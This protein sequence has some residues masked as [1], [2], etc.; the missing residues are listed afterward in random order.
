MQHDE[1]LDCD[2]VVVEGFQYGDELDLTACA[3]YAAV[4]FV[5]CGAF[6]EPPENCGW[7]EVHV[8]RGSVKDQSLAGLFASLP[9]IARVHIEHL[10]DVES[11][12]DL[13]PACE[14]LSIAHCFYLRSVA[15]G[16]APRLNQLFLDDCRLLHSLPDLRQ[17][18][19]LYGVHISACPELRRIDLSDF[20]AS[21]QVV[22]IE[23]CADVRAVVASRTVRDLKLVNLAG[24]R[25]LP[26]LGECESLE[27][28]EVD[29]CQWLRL[30]EPRGNPFEVRPIPP[31]LERMSFDG[32]VHITEAVVKDCFRPHMQQAGR[33]V[34][35]VNGGGDLYPAIAERSGALHLA[36]RRN[37]PPA[38]PFKRVRDYLGF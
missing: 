5:K 12:V 19:E 13:P 22:E 21:V 37:M 10:L 23:N 4:K 16:N 2:C 38:G 24:L 3:R 30:R 33:P 27:S 20:P 17:N 18:K 29:S 8:V 26:D 15:C 32:C 1:D 35:R 36:A 6:P 11:L 25:A 14:S 28:L 9:T 34:I 31:N 7:V